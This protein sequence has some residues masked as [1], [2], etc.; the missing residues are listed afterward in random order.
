HVAG[1]AGKT[2]LKDHGRKLGR[3]TG[4]DPAGPL[5]TAGSASTLAP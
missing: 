5:F 1:I 4:L 3:V 2:Y